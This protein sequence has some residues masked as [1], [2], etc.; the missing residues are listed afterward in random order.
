[1][2]G[3]RDC[4]TVLWRINL[5][6]KKTNCNISQKQLQI[7][8]ANNVYALRNT[9]ALVNY[10]HNT[11]FSCTKSALVHAV[12]KGHVATWPGLTVEA[13]NK[14]FKLT[15]ATAAAMGHINQ[16]RQNIPSTK[17]RLLEQEDEDITPLGSGG[18]THLVFAVVLDQGQIYTDL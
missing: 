4:A 9:G 8:S 13:I 16:K 18:K 7:H 1:M 15:A 17:E 5:Y 14:H 11:M 6:H 10:L 12:K 2:K 3:N